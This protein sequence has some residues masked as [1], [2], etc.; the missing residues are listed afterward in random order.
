[1][2][3]PS[4]P[5]LLVLHALGIKGLAPADAI[6]TAT[7]LEADE[8]EVVLAELAEAGLTEHRQGALAGW[9]LTPVGR[10]QRQVSVAEELDASGARSAVEGAYRRFSV[11]N[12]EL[13]ATCTAWQLHPV[14]GGAVAND[15]TDAEYDQAVIDRL[16]LVHGQVQPVLSALATSLERFAGYQPRLQ[17]ALDRVVAGQADW[18]TRPT[19]DSYHTVWFELHQDLLDTLGF[20]RG[21]EGERS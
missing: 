9:A 21:L 4:T 15:H 5:P 3:H 1:M 16:V 17:V 20:D 13:L 18:C 14:D 19:I 8:V 11:V 7:R 2:S 6:V 12:P 10:K